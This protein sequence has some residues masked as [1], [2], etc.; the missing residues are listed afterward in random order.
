MSTESY[1]FDDE[2]WMLLEFY[3]HPPVM[4][5]KGG[6]A[7]DAVVAA[8]GLHD[9]VGRRV[10]LVTVTGRTFNELAKG[11]GRRA[12]YALLPDGRTAM[13]VMHSRG[14]A[15]VTSDDGGD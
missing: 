4:A 8:L 1:V 3:G 14:L 9:R 15:L 12:R 13:T 7:M 2:H 10:S 11:A 6:A 5:R